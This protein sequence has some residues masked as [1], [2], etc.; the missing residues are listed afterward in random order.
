M[1]AHVDD[2]H[3][4]IFFNIPKDNQQQVGYEQ[5]NQYGH[6]VAEQFFALFSVESDTLALFGNVLL[7]GL[8]QAIQGV[9]QQSKQWQ[10]KGTDESGHPELS[11]MQGVHNE[12]PDGF[13]HAGAD[14]NTDT[15]KAGKNIGGASA[16]DEAEYHA[17][18]ATQRQTVEEHGEDII[19]S[20]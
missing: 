2:L 18:H 15:Q 5:E 9:T 13:C 17:P 6:E 7:G 3:Q 8:R 10:G 14:D 20:G 1:F 12:Q 4:E 11:Y 19:R 16:F